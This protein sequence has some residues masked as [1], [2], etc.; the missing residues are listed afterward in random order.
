MLTKL[1]HIPF[2]AQALE[3]APFSLV[4]C[5]AAGGID[6]F[7][8]AL[9]D[10]AGT[11]RFGFEPNPEE[12]KRLKNDSQTQYFDCALSDALGEATFYASTTLG[13]LTDRS[14]KLSGHSVSPV[15]VT[16]ETIDHLVGEATIQ[17]P[18]VIKTDVEGHDYSVIRGATECLDDVLCVK[19]EIQWQ[20][21]SAEGGFAAIHDLLVSKGFLLF[22]HSSNYSYLGALQ[23]GDVL[24]LKSV[25][26]VLEDSRQDDHKR[27]QLIRLAVLSC[28]VGY[29]EYAIVVSGKAASRGLLSTD[30]ARAIEDLLGGRVY[31]PEIFPVTG[32]GQKLALL[33]H[34]VGAVLLGYKHRAKSTPKSNQL[35]PFRRLW[36]SRDVPIPGSRSAELVA[37]RKAAVGQPIGDA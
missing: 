29:P 18:A 5:G 12:L 4:D 33:A 1:T 19:S 15:T 27:V 23:G 2:V 26:A 11:R 7:F 25:D 17:S 14:A 30:E 21:H 37:R 20:T 22:S 13:S 32:L 3:Q 24:Y 34:L 6:P 36:V 16:V 8:D 28:A 9:R 10:I 31:L 35:R